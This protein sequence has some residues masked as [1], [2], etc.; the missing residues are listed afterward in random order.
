METLLRSLNNLPAMSAGMYSRF[1]VILYQLVKKYYKNIDAQIVSTKEGIAVLAI[2]AFIINPYMG[3]SL[4]YSAEGSSRATAEGSS[5]ATA[6]GSSRATAEGSSRATAEGSP[7]SSVRRG[8]YSG[9]VD[10][11]LETEIPRSDEVLSFIKD[12][13]KVLENLESSVPLTVEN[14]AHRQS[15]FYKD[16][17]AVD[18]YP[19]A[20]T[21]VYPRGGLWKKMWSYRTKSYSPLPYMV[22][23]TDIPVVLE[24]KFYFPRDTCGLTY[25]VELVRSSD[26]LE[27][28]IIDTEG[29]TSPCVD[30]D[31]NFQE[32]N[33]TVHF[34]APGGTTPTGLYKP[35]CN[36]DS[37]PEIL[38][39]GDFA[40][41]GL[42]TCGET[43]PGEAPEGRPGGCSGGAP[44]EGSE[45][46]PHRIR[47]RVFSK[48]RGQTLVLDPKNP[49]FTMLLRIDGLTVHPLSEA[50]E[51]M[52]DIPLQK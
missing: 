12:F 1:T 25:S 51:A 6:E 52:A 14:I 41:G 26:N 4:D 27:V 8:A 32:F 17:L 9:N 30:F 37:L 10:Y 35:G 40:A 44:G 24:S 3:I 13:S 19:N 33:P 5:R 28:E 21:I 2:N 45:G 49:V 18:V 46:P 47:Y 31:E 48:I 23:G 43:T 39:H 7:G 42:F 22:T 20:E 16:S 34:I 11:F 15:G 36:L 29:E 50:E 38:S